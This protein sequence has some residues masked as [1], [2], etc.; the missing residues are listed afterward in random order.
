MGDH[1]DLA[2]SGAATAPLS[3]LQRGLWFL[4]QLD[5]GSAAYNI[6]WVLDLDGPVQPQ[7]LRRAFRRGDRPARGAAHHVLRGAG[8]AAPGDPG[9]TWSFRST[10]PTCARCPPASGAPHSTRRSTATPAP[11][12]DLG[13]GPLLRAR[14]IRHADGTDGQ[15][16]SLLIVVFHHIVFDEW[17]LGVFRRDL[18]ELYAAEVD[19]RPPALPDLPVQYADYSTWEQGVPRETALD[20][21]RG[22]L[23]DAPSVTTLPADRPRPARAT[24]GRR[25]PLLRPGPGHRRAGAR[26]GRGHRRDP[27]HRAAGRLRRP[28]R[29]VHPRGGPR[30]RHPGDRARPSR[31]RPPRRLLRERRP[32]AHPGAGTPR[33]SGTWSS[34]SGTPSSTATRIRTPLWT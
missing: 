3:G 23:A 25:H 10:R 2:R 29:P 5:P 11:P 15:D 17:S 27:V 20:F 32:A 33:A 30:H 22:R 21:W 31:A 6:P 8:R 14:L 19:G 18:A 26:A 12:F 13:R 16:R 28:G 34:R 7:A 1:H 24:A 4:D 9:R